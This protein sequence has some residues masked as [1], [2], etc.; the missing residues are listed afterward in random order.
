MST[1]T[2]PMSTTTNG[3]TSDLRAAI[4]EL[5]DSVVGSPAKTGMEGSIASS[6][7]TLDRLAP[8]PARAY[9]IAFGERDASIAD[10]NL[11]L[12]WAYHCIGALTKSNPPLVPREHWHEW[13]D[14]QSMMFEAFDEA[15][16]GAA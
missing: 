12:A 7:A 5:A 9:P 6:L 10:G 13:L 15:V 8:T 1:A 14:N 4:R 16:R 11:Q 3:D 2:A